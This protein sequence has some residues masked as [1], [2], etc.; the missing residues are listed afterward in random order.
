[1]SGLVGLEGEGVSGGIEESDIGA[2][3]TLRTA[4]KM[5]NFCTSGGADIKLLCLPEGPSTKVKDNGDGTYLL[6][7]RSK[8][9]GNFRS[10]VTIGNDD[11]LGSPMEFTLTSSDPDLTKSELTGEG[12]R[13]CA[14]GI[15]AEIKIKFVTPVCSD[16]H[17]LAPI[18]PP[19]DLP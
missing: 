19:L 4:D 10:R 17:P 12:L 1:M 13:A 16:I 8:A 5:G 18:S 11:V 15:E 9:S 14:A 3:I 7:W 6:E 2:R